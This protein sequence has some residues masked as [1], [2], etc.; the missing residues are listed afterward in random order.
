MLNQ[1]VHSLSTGKLPDQSHSH[2]LK[3]KLWLQTSAFD[4][5]GNLQMLLRFLWERY[6]ETH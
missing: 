1:S 5:T 4:Y 2:L 6:I 3:T